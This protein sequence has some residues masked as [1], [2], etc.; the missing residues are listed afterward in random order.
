M[1]EFIPGATVQSIFSGAIGTVVEP[2]A[3]RAG[4]VTVAF[5]IGRHS[6]A[7]NVRTM[8]LLVLN[9][10]PKTFDQAALAVPE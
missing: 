5:K 10:A 6:Q 2:I 7:T 3:C 9:R 1:N 4:H 8:D